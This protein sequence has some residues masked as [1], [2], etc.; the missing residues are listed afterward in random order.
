VATGAAFWNPLRGKEQDMTKKQQ[1][2]P[3]THATKPNR[4]QRRH[5]E[6]LPQDQTLA[7]DTE[8]PAMHVPDVRAMN[9]GH[10]TKTANK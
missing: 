6:G 4:A 10:G 7:R 2:V 1:H 9:T 3:G 5:P 8:T